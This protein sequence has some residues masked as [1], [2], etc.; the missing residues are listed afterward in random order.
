MVAV[1][2][3]HKCRVLPHHR[4]T[5]NT[6]Y[7]WLWFTVYSH[8][9][10]SPRPPPCAW[11]CIAWE[12]R[13]S[14]RRESVAGEAHRRRWATKRQVAGPAQNIC[15][16]FL[17]RVL[18]LRPCLCLLACLRRCVGISTSAPHPAGTLIFLHEWVMVI[19]ANLYIHSRTV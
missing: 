6:A 14:R 15:C 3:V 11:G 16:G 4:C 2:R 13:N 9:S 1:P 10:I 17:W 7:T 12:E 18:V 5:N 8:L 19:C